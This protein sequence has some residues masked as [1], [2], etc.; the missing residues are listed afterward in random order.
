[1]PYW[2]ISLGIGIVEFL[3]LPFPVSSEN[4]LGLEQLRAEDNSADLEKLG[5][6]PLDLQSSI[7]KL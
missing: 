3:H 5:I 6:Q 4:L 1:V 7:D 2:L